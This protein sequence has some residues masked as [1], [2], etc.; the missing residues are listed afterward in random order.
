MGSQYVNKLITSLCKLV[1][2]EKMETIAYSKEENGLVERANKEI[3]RHLRAI[4]YQRDIKKDWRI[5]LPLIQR[6]MNATI[7]TSTG[8]A[9]A[10]II[11]PGIDL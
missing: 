4:L 3:L 2:S 1:G 11:T 7:H 6:I 5:C 9:P 8:T 10:S